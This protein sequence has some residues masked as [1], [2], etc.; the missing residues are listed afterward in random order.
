[1]FDW[2]S[3]FF[4]CYKSDFFKGVGPRTFPYRRPRVTSTTCFN[5]L[6]FIDS[7]ADLQQP[8]VSRKYRPDTEQAAHPYWL[9]RREV[10][11][12]SYPSTG[13]VECKKQTEDKVKSNYTSLIADFSLKKKKSEG[14][15]RNSKNCSLD[16][17]SLES[18]KVWSQA[19][20]WIT[21]FLAEK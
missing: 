2:Q 17:F 15:K 18:H 4:F 16:S 19:L 5:R 21:F 13:K 3:C 1:M 10:K 8:S 20:Y 11:H 9:S 6:G 12:D 7:F 14:E